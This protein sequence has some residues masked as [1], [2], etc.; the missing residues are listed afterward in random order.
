MYVCIITNAFIVCIHTHIHLNAYVQKP[1]LNVFLNDLAPH[2][3]YSLRQG[4]SVS[5]GLTNWLD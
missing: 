2:L 4:L 5:L 3:P 1:T